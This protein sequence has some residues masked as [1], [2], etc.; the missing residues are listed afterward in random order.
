MDYYNALIHYKDGLSD[1]VS[2]IDEAISTLEGYF[3]CLN[4]DTLLHRSRP[5]AIAYLALKEIKD[6]KQ[7]E[8]QKKMETKFYSHGQLNDKEIAAALRKAADQYENGE[9]IEVHDLLLDIVDAIDEF[10][11]AQEDK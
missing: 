5:L 6:G 9:I 2:L 8:R 1:D 4:G 3:G 7:E 11:A 10:Y